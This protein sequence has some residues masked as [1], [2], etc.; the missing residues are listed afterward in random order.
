[1]IPVKKTSATLLVTSSQ[2]SVRNLDSDIQ[3]FEV[4][5]E[6]PTEEQEEE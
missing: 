6:T 1:V 3:I 4:E 5:E 2:P